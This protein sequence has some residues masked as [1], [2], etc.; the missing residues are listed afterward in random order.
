[1]E[2][3][4]LSSIDLRDLENI[5][6]FSNLRLKMLSAENTLGTRFFWTPT[7]FAMPIMLK[8]FSFKFSNIIP[9]ETILR[10]HREP[11]L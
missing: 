3:V 6:Q 7:L 10:K 8:K 4:S 2:I 11:S 9:V 5:N 1:M